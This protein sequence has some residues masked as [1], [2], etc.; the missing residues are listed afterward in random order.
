MEF[1]YINDKELENVSGGFSGI[2]VYNG[3]PNSIDVSQEEYDALV[4]GGIIIDGK[5]KNDQVFRAGDY[6]KEKGFKGDIFVTGAR[7]P[8]MTDKAS[9]E[10]ATIKI[11]NNV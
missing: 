7:E 11:K 3:Q 4:E 2:V 1:E 10:F 6:L 9:P 8:H 5:L